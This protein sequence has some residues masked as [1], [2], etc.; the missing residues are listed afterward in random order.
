MRRG[1]LLVLFT[2]F[3]SQFTIG[4]EIAITERGDSVVLLS[5]GTWDYYDSFY[6]GSEEKEEIRTNEKTFSKPSTAVKKINGK[7]QAYEVWYDD[8]IWRRIPI[9]E[10]NPEADIALQLIK[11]DVYAMV[12][13]EEIEIPF[14][15]LAQIALNNAVNAAPDIKLVDKEYRVVNND[16]LICMQM[17][18]TAQGMKVTYYSYYFSNEKGS[19]QFHTFTGQSLVDKYKNEIN[20]L[21][22][23]LIS[24]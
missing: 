13:Y 4:Q 12:I 17:D 10:I 1:I 20:D 23:G 21:L 14:D 2:I 24:K 11:G 3:I 16:T 18:G 9:G 22:N 15:N 5:N 7:N 8:K 19:I 6:S